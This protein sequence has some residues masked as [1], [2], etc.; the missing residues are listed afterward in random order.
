MACC[1]VV[2][3]IAGTLLSAWVRLRGRPKGSGGDARAWHLPDGR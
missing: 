3:M 1:V 2:A